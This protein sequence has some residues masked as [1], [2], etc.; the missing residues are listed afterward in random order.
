MLKL[1]HLLLAGVALLSLTPYI[2]GGPAFANDDRA[3]S[4]SSIYA[5]Y[6]WWDIRLHEN[7]TCFAYADYDFDQHIRIGVNGADNYYIMLTSPGVDKLRPIND[8]PI[9]AKFDNGE[10]YQGKVSVHMLSD[11][12]RK[13]MEFPIGG[14]MLSSFMEANTMKIHARTEQV[15][16]LLVATMSLQGSYAAM[17]KTAECTSANGG[18]YSRP[19]NPF[20]NASVTQ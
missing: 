18:H 15:G 10:S 3:G 5:R 13:V 12:S 9:V 14:S 16:A 19:S 11:G 20:H 1:R 17:L 8:F 7:G 2:A 4:R 6:G